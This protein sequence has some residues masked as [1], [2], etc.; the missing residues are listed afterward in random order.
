MSMTRLEFRQ[1]FV[2]SLAPLYDHREAQALFRHYVEERLGVEYYLFLLDR[3]LP[4]DLPDG[5]DIDIDVSSMTLTDAGAITLSMA[6]NIIGVTVYDNDNVDISGN[7]NVT[8][9]C[10]DAPLTVYK[11]YITIAAASAEKAYDG[12]ALTDDNYSVV[13]GKL[14]DGDTLEVTVEGSV[15]GVGDAENVITSVRIINADGRDVT[16]NYDITR[17][18]G[19]LTVY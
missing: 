12:T 9:V 4:A 18:N 7:V 5:W 11:L 8:F 19:T 2:Q 16:S 10:K 1:R 13:T 15:I 6:Q 3:E 14:A 17:T